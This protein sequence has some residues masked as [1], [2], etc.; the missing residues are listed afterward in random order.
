MTFSFAVAAHALL[1]SLSMRG[2]QPAKRKTGQQSP[3]SAGRRETLLLTL[4]IG[5]VLLCI[6][7]WA[8]YLAQYGIDIPRADQFNTPAEQIEAAARGELTFNLLIQQHNESRKLLPNLISLSLYQL[9]GFWDVR[10]ELWLSWAMGILCVVAVAQLSWLT[11]RRLVNTATLTALFSGLLW[12]AHTFYFH[13]FSVTFERFLPQLLLVSMMIGFLRYGISWGTVISASLASTLAQF[14]YASGIVVWPLMLVTLLLFEPGNLRRNRPKLVFF[15][16]SAIPGFWLF[17]HDYATPIHHTPLSAI[18]DVSIGSM[19]VYV[20]HFLGNSITNNDGWIS[21]LGILM[22]VTYLVLSTHVLFS[23]REDPEWKARITWVVV[24]GYSLA[25]AIL[26]MIGR[27]PMKLMP[28]GRLDY[29]THPFYLIIAVFALLLLAMPSRA[30]KT[31]QIMAVGVAMALASTSLKPALGKRMLHLESNLEYG[32]TCFLLLNHFDQPDCLDALS[33]GIAE[34]P[35]LLERLSPLL[36]QPIQESLEYGPD[37]DPHDVSWEPLGDSMVAT[38][39]ARLAGRKAGAVVAIEHQDGT[40]TVIG[41]QRI[42]FARSNSTGQLEPLPDPAGWIMTLN[43]SE[44]L[45]PCALRIYAMQ[46]E[47]GLLHEITDARPS[48]CGSPGVSS[49]GTE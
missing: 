22:G 10:A 6:G 45:D 18:L 41:I 27:L 30:Q 33:S 5:T 2:G 28:E 12:S 17:F 38:G 32:R 31:I 23:K 36:R 9:R 40:D 19:F 44:T 20:I 15:L 47:T 29:V 4:A 43:R 8:W 16:L 11:T 26:S 1:P 35:P 7:I 37:S 39:I 42:G 25:Q 49:Q 46:N 21:I 24:G 48:R 14:S 3:G 13:F 34:H